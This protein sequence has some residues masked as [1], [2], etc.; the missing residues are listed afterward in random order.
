LS[1]T[2]DT[3]EWTGTE[4]IFGISKDRGKTEIRFT[5]RG[6]VSEFECFNDFSNGW[7]FYING[8]LPSLIA[9]GKGQPNQLSNEE[10][11]RLVR[12]VSR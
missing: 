8:S 5:H 2:E 1:F 6:L 9:T 3:S 10:K 11:R 12:D 7:N 4:I